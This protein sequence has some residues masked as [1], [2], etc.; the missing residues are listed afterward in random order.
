MKKLTPDF[1][2]IAD[3]R[4]DNIDC[5]KQVFREFVL[6]CKNL[7]LFGGEL[8][9][10]DGSRF[11]AVNSRN[12]N[13]NKKRLEEKLE[14]IDERI[15][16]FLEEIDRADDEE[17]K[18]DPSQTSLREK[19]QKLGEKK[20]EYQKILNDLKQKGQKEI[21]LTDPE[22]RLM[23]VDNQKLDVC[24]NVQSVVDAKNHL[25]CDYG[26]T[27]SSSDYNQ[28]SPMAESA[29]RA[30]GVDRLN[31]AADSGYYDAEEIKKCI[32]GGV[33]PYIPMSHPANPNKRT[34][35]PAK[36]FYSDR[37]TYDKETDT[38]LCPAG[39]EMKFWKWGKHFRQEDEAL[40]DSLLQ[41]RLSIQRIVHCKQTRQNNLQVGVR[42]R[43]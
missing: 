25:V 22:S 16:E 9:T 38:F 32:E 3:F 20:G 14:K 34:G 12:R 31:V 39:M 21:S 6:V 1:K 13:F 5:I 26:V 36:E 40:L 33:V 7:N 42:C 15:R 23:R 43:D 35:V 2:T 19:I 4:K 24:Y 41:Q 27:N 28:L 37:F 11:K 18:T 10:I 29:K 17:K 8:V 30:L